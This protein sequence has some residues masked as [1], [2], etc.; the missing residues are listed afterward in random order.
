MSSTGGWKTEMAIR[1]TLMEL[2]P[3]LK[4]SNTLRAASGRYSSLLVVNPKLVTSNN[5]TGMVVPIGVP[6]ETIAWKN[7]KMELDQVGPTS[8]E[9]V[10]CLVM[11][12]GDPSSCA[13]Q[14]VAEIVNLDLHEAPASFAPKNRSATSQISYRMVKADVGDDST[15]V[16]ELG[17]KSLPS[18][19]MFCGPSMLYAGPVG[20][21]KVKAA[22]SVQKPQILI[23]EPNFRHQIMAEKTLRKL[24]CDTFLCLSIHEAVERIRQ[25]SSTLEGS[26][27]LTF[28][29]V[30][31]SDELQAS[32]DLSTLA[33]QLDEV[34]VSKRTVMC[35]AVDVLGDRGMHNLKAAKWSANFCTENVSAVL[36]LPLASLVQIAIQKPVKAGA[37]EEL[38][39]R[40]TVNAE[41]VAF[42]LTPETLKSKMMAAAGNVGSGGSRSGQQHIQKYVGIKLSAEDVRMRGQGLV[43]PSF[44]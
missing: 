38:L 12:T 14:R 18:F 20:G 39:T 41:E 8:S 44:A 36:Q 43:A 21:R 1:S 16:S 35:A 33:R 23:I 29:V 28:D 31:I 11:R 4:R 15:V 40:R 26:P 17:I 30:I 7:L 24:G 5:P 32:P 13:S 22:S 10:V 25:F 37:L 27:S 34:V 2:N 6:L 19:V 9:V 3:P 42:G